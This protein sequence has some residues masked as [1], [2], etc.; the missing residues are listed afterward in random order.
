LATTTALFTHY[1]VAD[2][3]NQLA[4]QFLQAVL[5][6]PQVAWREESPGLTA[7]WHQMAAVR[8][9]SPKVWMDAYL[10]AFAISGILTLV[11][12]D[13]DFRTYARYGLDCEVLAAA[14]RGP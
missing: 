4:R 6:N 7:R 5:D 14:P 9:P 11:T 13:K 1:G 2:M 12:L 8:S 10:A 3:T